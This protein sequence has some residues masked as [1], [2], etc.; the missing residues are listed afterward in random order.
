MA[1][2]EARG[3][4]QSI[5][6]ERPLLLCPSGVY[7]NIPERGITRTHTEGGLGWTQRSRSMA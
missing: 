4:L 1:P 5:T 6:I 2:A 7:Y 3:T